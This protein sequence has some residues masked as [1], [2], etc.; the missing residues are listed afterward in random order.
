MFYIFF[1]APEIDICTVRLKYLSFSGLIDLQILDKMPMKN[2]RGKMSILLRM[3]RKS[4][5]VCG[6]ISIA[7]S[8]FGDQQLVPRLEGLLGISFPSLFRPNFNQNPPINHH[9]NKE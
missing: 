9:V 8:S 6:I 5:G 4:F 7:S 2:G 3:A 1:N